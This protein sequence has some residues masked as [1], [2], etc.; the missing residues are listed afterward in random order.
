MFIL[1]AVGGNKLIE[2]SLVD[3]FA[4]SLLKRLFETTRESTESMLP[5]RKSFGLT[6]LRE[7]EVFRRC[8]VFF[9]CVWV[10]SLCTSSATCLVLFRRYFKY[11]L[12][13]DNLSSVRIPTPVD[14]RVEVSQISSSSESTK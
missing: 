9:L 7:F 1:E 6:F 10:S 11:T 2:A 12:S 3:E 14:V 13:N 8:K 5:L 4:L